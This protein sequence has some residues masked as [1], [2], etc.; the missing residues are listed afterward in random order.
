MMHP[1]N[2]HLP[3]LKTAPRT[4]EPLQGHREA[5]PRLLSGN[6]ARPCGA[7]ASIM[8]PTAAEPFPVL[9]C[10][11]GRL[12]FSLTQGS[13]RSQTPASNRTN[14]AAHHAKQG[15]LESAATAIRQSF[16]TLRDAP[17]L[18]LLVPTC[19]TDFPSLGIPNGTTPLCQIAV[20]RLHGLC[21]WRG[22]SSSAIE[23]AQTRFQT[24]PLKAP[25][26]IP[27]SQPSHWGFTRRDCPL[28]HATRAR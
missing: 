18:V 14:P 19:D 25:S 11:G 13:G 7:G 6:E 17:L 12:L 22:R 9:L 21:C 15:I 26:C 24:S 3:G 4:G 23:K 27:G 8:R 2:S 16:P 5:Y 28:F 10:F 1:A 20:P